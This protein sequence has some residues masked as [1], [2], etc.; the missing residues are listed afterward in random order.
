MGQSRK[1]GME[2]VRIRHR[3]VLYKKSEA[4]SAVGKKVLQQGLRKDFSGL[5]SVAQLVRARAL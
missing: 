4:G 5:G 2:L 3:E 1:N